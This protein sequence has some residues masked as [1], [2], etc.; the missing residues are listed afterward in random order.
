[1]NKL[2]IQIKKS[3]VTS[4]ISYFKDALNNFLPIFKKMVYTKKLMM[5]FH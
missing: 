2:S 5:H 3:E 4:I 1:L